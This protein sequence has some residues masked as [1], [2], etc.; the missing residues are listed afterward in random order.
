MEG[1]LVRA[2][3]HFRLHDL[4]IFKSRFAL[5]AESLSIRPGD[6]LMYLGTMVDEDGQTVKNRLVFVFLVR[7]VTVGASNYIDRGNDWSDCLSKW[8]SSG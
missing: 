7:G 8:V 6:A 1:E 5:R 2:T 4:A 3:N